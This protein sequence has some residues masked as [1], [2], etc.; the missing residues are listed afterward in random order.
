MRLI[1]LEWLKKKHTYVGTGELLRTHFEKIK[2][3]YEPKGVM[4]T[5]KGSTTVKL[6]KLSNIKVSPYVKPRARQ[7][8][9]TKIRASRQ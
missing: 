4:T 9:I 5:Q 8:D 3:T 7:E 6:L 2:G 1:I